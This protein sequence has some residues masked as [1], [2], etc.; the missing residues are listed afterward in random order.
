MN[1]RELPR[2]KHKPAAIPPI[3]GIPDDWMPVLGEVDADLVLASALQTNLDK[4]RIILFRH[5]PVQRPGKFSV[6]RVFDRPHKKRLLIFGEI[7]LEKAFLLFK[8]SVHPRK[9]RLLGKIVPVRPEIL[10][11]FWRLGHHHHAG[12][13]AVETVHKIHLLPAAQLPFA[14]IVVEGIFDGM[15]AAASG[16][17]RE[18]PRRLFDDYYIRILL[19]DIDAFYMARSAL[20][21]MLSVLP[22]I[23]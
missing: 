23:T 12:C 5:Y 2:M 14:D 6:L 19:E 10:L 4:R 21:A 22:T 18:N 3:T 11:H 8:R 1:E 16:C 17:A 13:L 9:I 15:L 7:A 20:H